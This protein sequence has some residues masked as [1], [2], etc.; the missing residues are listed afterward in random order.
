MLKIMVKAQFLSL[1]FLLVACASYTQ[2]SE[3]RISRSEYIEKYKEEAIREMHRS[4]V[5]ASITLA[6]GILES[7]D[8]NSPLARYAKN[9]FGIKCHTEWD[10]PTFHKD[11]DR[12]DECFRKYYD[13]YE[14]YKD[15]SDFLMGRS[16]YSNLFKL[17]ITDYKGWAKGLKKAGYATNPKYDDL[18]IKLIEQNDLAKYDRLGKTPPKKV[19]AKKKDKGAEVKKVNRNIK[20]HDNGIEYTIVREG[21]TFLGIAEDYDMNAWQLFKY[22]DKNENDKLNKGEVIY[23]QPK[24]NRGNKKFHKVK[25]GETMWEISQKYGIKLKKLYRKNRMIPGTQPRAGQKLHLKK[26]KKRERKR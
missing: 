1:F 6:Q 19:K 15:H 9:H 16:R 2:P 20:V 5:P 3:Y 17:K 22:N 10:G 23:L 14:S 4:G 8:G 12:K 24:R 18:L 21:D 7:G 25:E 11:D 26:R 13:V